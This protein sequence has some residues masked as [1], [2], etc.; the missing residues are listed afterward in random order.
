MTLWSSF[1]TQWPRAALWNASPRVCCV[2]RRADL[3]FMAVFCA[4]SVSA[5]WMLMDGF[6]YGALHGV[7]WYS[8]RQVYGTET[9]SP[10]E[11]M[12]YFYI[13]LACYKLVCFWWLCMLSFLSFFVSGRERES[14]ARRRRRCGKTSSIQAD[15]QRMPLKMKATG[16]TCCKLVFTNTE[17]QGKQRIWSKNSDEYCSKNRW[18]SSLHERKPNKIGPILNTETFLQQT[19][20]Q[21]QRK[22]ILSY[23]LIQ[24][25]AGGPSGTHRPGQCLMKCSSQDVNVS[26]SVW[27]AIL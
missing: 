19:Q 22:L 6:E 23:V 8:C 11:R 4:P 3:H 21:S 24:F 5:C 7:V 15:K 25:F 16:H 12:L 2:W 1:S 10:L 9:A 20:L 17:Q 14:Q 13:S 27:I 18:W 26:C